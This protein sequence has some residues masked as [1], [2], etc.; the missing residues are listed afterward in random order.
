MCKNRQSVSS[1]RGLTHGVCADAFTI[2]EVMIVVVIIGI[3]AAVVVPMMSSAASMQVRA[4]ASMVAADLEYAKSMSISHAREYCVVFSPTA[5]TYQIQDP[6]G[7]VI[8]HPVRRG[9]NY[10]INFRADGRLNRVEI[11]DTNL[12]PNDAVKFDYLGSPEYG[13]GAALSSEAIIRLQ[14]GGITKRV[15]VEPVTGFITVSD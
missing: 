6:N 8:P 12:D 1:D 15:K 13:S 5:E 14:A 2:F 9:S 11:V 10:I 4:A 3:A 7:N